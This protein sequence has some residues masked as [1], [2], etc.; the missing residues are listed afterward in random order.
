[1]YRSHGVLNWGFIN[2]LWGNN[3]S[4][5][6]TKQGFIISLNILNLQIDQENMIFHLVAINY[7]SKKKK[8]HVHLH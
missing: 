4:Q 7:Y 8:Q 1:M 2:L 6:N 3:I 5:Q